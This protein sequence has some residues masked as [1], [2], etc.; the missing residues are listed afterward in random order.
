MIHGY[1]Y[2]YE[3]MQC[4]VNGY[5]LENFQEVE[6][7]ASKAHANIHGRG[8]VP[9]AMS[10]GKKDAEPGRLVVLQSDFEAMNMAAP[11]GTDPTDWKAFEMIISYAPEGGII[12]TDVVPFCRVNSWKK[13]MKTEDGHQTIELSLTT[14]IPQLNV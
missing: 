12:I 5:P 8:A 11:V 1:E 13:G 7:G 2:A 6:Y 14:G 4:V 10:R 9:V 3:D